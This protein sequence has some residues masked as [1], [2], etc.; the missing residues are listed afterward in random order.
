VSANL[1]DQLQAALGDAYTIER[2]LEGGGMSRLFLATERSLD[3]PVV[4]KLL[5]PELASE[6]SA[7]R[8]QREI[9]TA[10]HLQHPHILPVLG[11][12]ARDGLL[13]YIMPYV[14]GESL[15]HR[16][17]R[18]GPLPVAEAVR[19]LREVADALACAHAQGI[20]HR[21]VKPEN[22][23]LEHGHAVLA[24]FGVARALE[25]TSSGDRL[26]A[27]GAG[28]GTPGYMAP[29]Q[30]AGEANLDARADV[31]ALGVI[32]Y[33]MLAGRPPFTGPTPMAIL[34]AHLTDA[35][36]PLAAM[37]PEV[38]RGV[39]EA[40]ANALAKTPGERVTAAAF[41]EAL[42]P[43]EGGGG[44]A[45]RAW[46]TA[47][48][49]AVAALV[50]TATLQA[51]RTR[52]AGAAGQS[53]P[54]RIA[55]P[56]FR[57]VGPDLT[58]WREGLV[59]LLAVNLDG[60]V[61]LRV[62]DPGTL[63]SRWRRE[64]GEGGEPNNDQA[65]RVARDLGARYALL[66]SIVGAGPVV[67]LSVSVYDVRDNTLRGTAQ[68]EGS[69]D[70]VL[71]LVDRL[72]LQVLGTGLVRDRSDI[73]ELDL[74]RLTTTSL[75]ALK[76][77]LAGEQKFRRAHP[78]EAVEDFARAVDTDSTFALA[79]YRLSLA[80]GWV[81]S[82]HR[83]RKSDTTYDQ[84]AARLA[85][86]LSERDR[87]L[88]R[89]NAQLGQFDPRAL[90]TLEELTRRHP[91]DADA[92]FL[93]GDAYFHLGGATLRP[94]DEFRN[95]ARRA[96]T[97]DPGFAPGYVHLIED[98]FDRG[99]S[100]DAR[101]LIAALRTIDPSSPKARGA[102]IA[103]A[104]VW[105][106]AAARRE[107]AAGLD[108]VDVDALLTAKHA[109]NYAPELW[110]QCLAVAEA[111]VR[112]PR[113]APYARLQAWAGIS[114]MYMLRGRFREA[115]RA[116]VAMYEAIGR[117]PPNQALNPPF[118]YLVG[119]E[120][121]ADVT[122]A[123]PRITA[124]TSAYAR[125]LLGAV[126][127]RE[128]RWPEAAHERRALDSL[129]SAAMARGDSAAA[130]SDA[131]SAHALRGFEAASRGNRDAAIRTLREAD[132]SSTAIGELDPLLR[133]TLARLLIDAGELRE[134]E[135]YLL[136]AR[137]RRELAMRVPAEFLLGRIAEATG[138]TA[139][140]KA[141]YANFL[142]WWADADSALQAR[143]N[144]GREAL[145]RLTREPVTVIPVRPAR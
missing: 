133:L 1:R 21:D 78:R 93:L 110:R 45:Q 68:V 87:L 92:W 14:A 81:S 144:E 38:P 44:R 18:E 116:E 6:V 127:A 70:S 12:G 23:L 125:Y 13:Y 88:M 77:Y 113:Q 79:L 119:A 95:A 58:L 120:N 142:R 101:A 140:A 20:I 117:P 16:L 41:R 122:A 75:P 96:L 121:H 5:P 104:L 105:G 7:A 3:R 47:T 85:G 50:L 17:E 28:V 134:A 111:I 62:I 135:R 124:D 51:I 49:L 86:Q 106:D 65:L 73:P 8:F 138:D 109:L 26:T 145:A 102:E 128:E 118:W 71:T 25:H 129:A 89:G 19:L 80:Q 72:T 107:T 2:E 99:D 123:L 10:A 61:G 30:L 46:R 100:S 83:F 67:R 35:P 22:I 33:E 31:Y 108:T 15:R 57:T 132:D 64:L 56:P 43:A 82:P 52:H 126:A 130:A 76:A 136:A 53:A 54:A 139:Q 63:L 36:T 60:V 69:P 29:E 84:R 131:A 34:A 90:Q 74:S 114:G 98:A 97:L 115:D 91:D 32:G 103:Y 4:I 143:L 40:I 48:L 55:I 137:D 66:G 42:A 24:D 112:Q 59:D 94:S 141:H 11:T 39:S 27:T 9:T 37:R